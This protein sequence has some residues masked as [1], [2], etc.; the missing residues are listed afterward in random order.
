MKRVA[1]NLLTAPVH[2]SVACFNLANVLL[3]FLPI[4]LFFSGCQFVYSYTLK[5]EPKVLTIAQG[6]SATLNVS[7]IYIPGFIAYPATPSQVTLE[8][9]PQGIEAEPVIFEVNHEGVMTISA[10]NDAAL[11]T[12]SVKVLQRRDGTGLLFDEAILELTVVAPN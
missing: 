6:S 4:V 7:Y 5:L 3:L 2:F 10:A 11:G 9:P 12:F 1:D 8:S